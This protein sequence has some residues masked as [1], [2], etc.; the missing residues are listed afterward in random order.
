M[1]HRNMLLIADNLTIT[2]KIVK[3]ALDTMD[4]EPIRQLVRRCEA[5]GAG[6]IDINPGPLGRDAG[7]R[8]AFF[9]ETV[10]GV[11]SL[12]LVIDTAEPR[13]ME[14]GLRACRNRAVINGF[15]LEPARR[16]A[17][18]AL[19][20]QCDAEMICFLL[21]P[22]GHVPARAEERLQVV[23]DVFEACRAAGI[24]RGRLIIDPILVPVTWQ[25]GASWNRELLSVL[26]QLPDV[27]GFPVKT[28]AGLSNL[29][30]STGPR[31]KKLLLESACLCMLAEAGLSMV[32]MNILHQET[33]RAARA[34]RALTQP[35]VFTWEEL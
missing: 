29:T 35:G 22:D 8:M 25:D 5:A 27:L 23:C 24:E 33:V 1:V 7:S 18:L 26:R 9:I 2:S 14:A 10:Q 6:A 16:D 30:A 19:A 32:L 17:M 20:A 3:Q 13:A 4:P 34:C 15:S 11:T 31:D 12:P 28:I 21:R